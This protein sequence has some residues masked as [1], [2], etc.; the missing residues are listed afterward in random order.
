M[1]NPES[2]RKVLHKIEDTAFKEEIASLTHQAQQVAMNIRYKDLISVF[3]NNTP[4]GSKLIRLNVQTLQDLVPRPGDRQRVVL[5]DFGRHFNSSLCRIVD[6]TSTLTETTLEGFG[7]NE[8]FLR[9]L[10]IERF[11]RSTNFNTIFVHDDD[12]DGQPWDPNDDADLI[13]FVGDDGLINPENIVILR[14]ARY[15]GDGWLTRKEIYS[16]RNTPWAMV[17]LAKASNDGLNF[18]RINLE[19]QLLYTWV[20]SRD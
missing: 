17:N 6:E 12:D 7:H 18:G 2:F 20:F 8:R 9:V 19:D 11:T 16:S 13:P 5:V 4:R 15:Q 14:V 3:E 1:M 10:D